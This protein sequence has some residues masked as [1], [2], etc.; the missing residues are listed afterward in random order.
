M[1]KLFKRGNYLKEETIRG[2][3]VLLCNVDLQDGKIAQIQY[4]TN[5]KQMSVDQM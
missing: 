5:N 3:M 1:R 4:Q 2:N